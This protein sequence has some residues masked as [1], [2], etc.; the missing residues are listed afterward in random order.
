MRYDI[1]NRFTRDVQFSA[2][3]ESKGDELP[4]VK[5]GLAVCVAVKDGADLGGANL[6]EA[7]LAGA[8]LARAY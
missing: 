1:F 7:D 4:S 6:A 8:N 5:L 2:E 3:I